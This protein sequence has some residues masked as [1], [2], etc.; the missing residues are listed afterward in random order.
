[1]NVL[2]GVLL[3]FCGSYFGDGF[4]EVGAV[5]KIKILVHY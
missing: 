5:I 1:V 2:L 3:D 4:G